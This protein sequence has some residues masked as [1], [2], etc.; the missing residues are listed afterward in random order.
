MGLRQK[1]RATFGCINGSIFSRRKEDTLLC[2]SSDQA[3]L[4]PHP[5]IFMPLLKE[6]FE[7]LSKLLK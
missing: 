6:A 4:G 1:P 7:E 3:L 5:Q 2:A